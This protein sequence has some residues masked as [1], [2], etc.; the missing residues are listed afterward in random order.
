MNADGRYDEVD[1]GATVADAQQRAGTRLRT[2]VEFTAFYRA[3]VRQL[4]FF[5]VN[6]GASEALAADVAQETMIKALRRWTDLE[7]PRAWVHKVASRELLRAFV[8]V[9]DPTAQMP[10]PTALLRTDAVAEW[11]TRHDA[12]LMLGDLPPR[13]RQVLAW[14][15]NDFTP[16]EIA[17]ILGVSPEAVRA[18]LKKARRA[19]ASYY[20]NQEDR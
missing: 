10:E 2:E 7:S 9:E 8:S 17:Q 13:Q 14:T 6:H 19:A 18:S 16:A 20:R 4:V 1:E 11:E 5:L 15:L 12:A 3:T